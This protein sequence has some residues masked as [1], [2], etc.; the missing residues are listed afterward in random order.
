[1]SRDPATPEEIE[2][3][4]PWYTRAFQAGYLELY[5]HRNQADAARAIG[6]LRERL[7]LRPGAR[8]LDLCCGAGRHLELL[9]SIL[10]PGDAVGLDLSRAL[11]ERVPAGRPVVEGD[12]R[13]LPF[14]GGSFDRVLNLFTSFG[15]FD[16][17]RENQVV[18][19]EMARVLVPGGLLAMDHINRNQLET[20]LQPVSERRLSEGVTVLEQREFDSVAS[21]V[22]KKVH[23]IDPQL[24]GAEWTESVRVY[25]SEEL[26]SMLE[27]AGLRVLERFGDYDGSELGAASPRMITLA[28]RRSD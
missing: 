20:T 9:C 27:E 11:L 1:M 2:R 12:M 13:R 19:N 14:A 4:P 5:S 17:E 16:D 8:A 3:D 24:G 26:G 6:F 15:Y 22:R 18:L 21:R 28:Q 25:R 7:E 23:W 10:R